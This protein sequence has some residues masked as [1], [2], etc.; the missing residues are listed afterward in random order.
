MIQLDHLFSTISL[1]T[2]Q[3]IAISHSTSQQGQHAASLR[4]PIDVTP[5]R[6]FYGFQ[7]PDNHNTHSAIIV[8]F[9]QK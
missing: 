9:P 8:T 3:I 2:R 1:L 5:L 6:T 4:L 7:Q